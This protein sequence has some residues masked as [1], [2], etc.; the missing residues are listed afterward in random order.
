MIMRM[1]RAC[2]A[3]ADGDAYFEYMQKAGLPRVR[4]A[5]G[6]QGV[7]VVRRMVQGKAE[8]LVLSL[9]DSMESISAFAGPDPTRAVF[10]PD[11]E[12][13]LLEYDVA[14]RLYDVLDAPKALAGRP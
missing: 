6:N 12:S 10:N 14:V 13:L 5:R 9:W 3:E 1:W 4:N 2:T 8:F 7:F 11:D